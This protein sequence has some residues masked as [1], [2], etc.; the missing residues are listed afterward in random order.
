MPRWI[1]FEIWRVRRR[2]RLLSRIYT[3]GNV[4][5]QV[6]GVPV[7]KFFKGKEVR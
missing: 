2:A 3:D 7:G 4:N 1:R 6:E 5:A